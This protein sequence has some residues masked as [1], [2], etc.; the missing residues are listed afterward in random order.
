M[1]ATALSSSINLSMD[2]DIPEGPSKDTF[3]TYWQKKAHLLTVFA[4]EAI[5]IPRLTCL[6][7]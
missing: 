7:G 6:T 3:A 2:A 5:A 4:K 1:N